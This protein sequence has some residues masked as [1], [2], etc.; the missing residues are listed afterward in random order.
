MLL[1]PEIAVRHALLGEPSLDGD[2]L[3]EVT[4]PRAQFGAQT[5]V[6][7]GAYQEIFST[8]LNCIPQLPETQRR[9]RITASF[10]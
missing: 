7:L 9:S 3:T 6:G 10:T 2:P 4:Q 1:R 8:D 5:G